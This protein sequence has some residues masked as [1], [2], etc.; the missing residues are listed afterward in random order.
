MNR[1]P[2][3]R[4]LF[5]YALYLATLSIILFYDI[6]AID[7]GANSYRMSLTGALS[8]ADISTDMAFLGIFQTNRPMLWLFMAAS[9]LA[10]LYPF[11]SSPLLRYASASAMYFSVTLPLAAFGLIIYFMVLQDN[12]QL[13]TTSTFDYFGAASN[14]IT[15]TEFIASGKVYLRST[16]SPFTLFLLA[17]FILFFSTKLLV[18]LLGS[19]H[20]LKKASTV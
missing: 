16:S 17:M 5:L 12:G 14:L 20:K 9:G 8:A 2:I 3:P 11:F 1:P 4:D 7:V 18:L 10:L 19:G 6:A 13:D 15:F